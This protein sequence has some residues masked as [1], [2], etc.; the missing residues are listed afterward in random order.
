MYKIVFLLLCISGTAFGKPLD[1]LVEQY[2]KNSPE[3]SQLKSK[4]NETSARQLE[5]KRAMY[6]TITLNGQAKRQQQPELIPFFVTPKRSYS[7]FAELYQPIY[8]GGKIRAGL[9]GRSVE[10]QLAKKEYAI[11]SDRLVMS[12]VS[13]VLDFMQSKQQQKILKSSEKTIKQFL[14]TTRNRHKKGGA[15]DYELAQA[16]AHYY[17][18][19]P[20]LLSS[21]IVINNLKTKIQINTGLDDLDAVT[22]GWE[23]IPE[24]N[25]L[26]VV[27]GSKEVMPLRGDY[28]ALLD[29][30]ELTKVYGKVDMAEFKPK[31]NIT[32]Q[33]GYQTNSSKDLFKERY[34]SKNIALNISVPLFSGFRRSAVKQVGQSQLV[35]LDSQL[36]KFE[37]NL[38]SQLSQTLENLNSSQKNLKNTRDWKYRSKKALDSAKKDF[39]KG[40]ISQNEIV[41]LQ[42]AYEAAA[43]GYM[44]SL[45]TFY[46]SKM[47]R[48][49]TLGLNL[50]EIYSRR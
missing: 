25:H 17:S 2:L 32:G 14:S 30:K 42:S 45:K 29:Q 46:L 38:E 10:H 5:A 22:W 7:A 49:M 21:S 23:K 44:S 12:F 36:K 33:F 6:P 39:K 9:R 31:I 28:K 4:I 24:I 40:L 3:I 13:D 15:R 27:S 41:Q 20:R 26:L 37:K 34:E 19:S 11:N 18:Y 48:E 8:L 35:G 50:S 1:I 43:T 47:N 16:Q